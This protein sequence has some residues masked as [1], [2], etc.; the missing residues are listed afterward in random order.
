MAKEKAEKKAAK[1]KKKSNLPP[2]EKPD[3]GIDYLAKAAGLETAT[4][5]SKLRTLK[6][7][8]D[9]R[10]YDFGTKAAADKIVKQLTAKKE[11]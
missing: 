3:Y 10:Q 2:L 5:R 6:I 1:G 7:K 4:V 9:G 11:D 8:K